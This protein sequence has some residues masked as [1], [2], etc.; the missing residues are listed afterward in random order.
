MQQPVNA[1]RSDHQSRVH[2][3]ADD[4]AQRIPRPFVEPVQ[5]LVE[6]MLDHVRRCPIIKPDNQNERTPEI[7]Q[8]L[9][10]S[11]RQTPQKNKLTRTH[12]GSN[13]WIILSKRMTAN[14]RD[15]KPEI[16]ANRR[17]AKVIKL[18]Q[19]A[20][21]RLI[22]A[23]ADLPLVLPPAFIVQSRFLYVYMSFVR[24]GERRYEWR[25]RLVGIA[26][27]IAALLRYDLS[28]NNGNATKRS[29][30]GRPIRVG[31]VSWW[32]GHHAS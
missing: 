4:T 21:F 32:C 29:C 11:H 22:I 13:S 8:P 24:L 5:E 16:Q 25:S 30:L 10:L 15:E 14:K 17:I 1:S 2:R 19:P 27:T 6:S 12:H 18:L 31:A 28:Q 23:N 7:N 26:S 9:L 3:S 20:V